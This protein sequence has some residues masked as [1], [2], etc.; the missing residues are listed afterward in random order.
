MREADVDF[1]AAGT[2]AGPPVAGGATMLSCVVVREEKERGCY[3]K[4]EAD[5]YH[6]TAA[7]R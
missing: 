2:G 6:A 4:A 7:V 1:G 3:A 5:M